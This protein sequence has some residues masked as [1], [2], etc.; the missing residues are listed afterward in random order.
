MGRSA[1]A[2]S[3]HP[4]A[5]T[6]YVVANGVVDEVLH[7]TGQQRLA[8]DHVGVIHGLPYLETPGGYDVAASGER[9]G[10]DVRQ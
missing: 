8:P 5:A 7:Q 1:I 10:N 9:G 2:P 4:N 6:W 3:C